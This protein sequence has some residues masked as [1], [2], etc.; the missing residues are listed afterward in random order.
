MGYE[1]KCDKLTNEIDRLNT[2][3]N[4]LTIKSIA[5]KLPD[6][7]KY[8]YVLCDCGNVKILRYGNILNK[9]TKTCGC[10]PRGPKIGS[11]SKRRKPIQ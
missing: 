9:N 7:G 10:G 1:N 5:F 6:K 11:K 2:K 8:E 4:Q 3:I